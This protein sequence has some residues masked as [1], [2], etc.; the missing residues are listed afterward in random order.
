MLERI[1]FWARELDYETRNAESH[2]RI[3]RA[4]RGQDC[5]QYTR[6][7]TVRSISPTENAARPLDNEQDWEKAKTLALQWC[8]DEGRAGVDVQVMVKY[9][10]APQPEPKPIF[11][12][13][14]GWTMFEPA[15]P[16]VPPTTEASPETG[17]KRKRARKSLAN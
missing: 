12:Q 11:R 14:R 7:V 1:S 15:N 17:P 9:G 16:G 13:K 8:K 10:S 5:I 4:S 6:H 3:K 2:R